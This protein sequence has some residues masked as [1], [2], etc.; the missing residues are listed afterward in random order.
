MKLG[1]FHC[2][3]VDIGTITGHPLTGFVAGDILPASVWDLGH[4][5]TCD[6]AG[7]V[8]C[9]KLDLWVDI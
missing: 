5:P 1:G 3:F 4:R 6:P 7:M 8:Y 9:A 2:E